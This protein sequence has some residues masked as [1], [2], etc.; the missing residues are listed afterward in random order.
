M[1]KRADGEL[2]REILNVLWDANEP[3]PAAEVREALGSTLAYTSVAT[4]L[5]R[6]WEKG[7]VQR[8]LTGRAFAYSPTLTREVWYAEQM[9]AVL[10]G[11]PNQR[12]LLVGFVDKLSRR[13]RDALRRLLEEDAQK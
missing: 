10:D 13:D 8:V 12:A 2:E 1:V 11:L 6:L 4:V 5:T 9:L 7:S 3:L